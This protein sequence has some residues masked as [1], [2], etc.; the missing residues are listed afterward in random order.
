MNLNM[1]RHKVETEDIILSTTKNCETL[2]KQ[3]HTKAEET[4]EFR[5]TRPKKIS[6]QSTYIC[7]KILVGW[8]NKLSSLQFFIKH[9]RRK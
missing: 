1:I 7:W 4:L 8:F 3:T 9:N 5:L 6:Y 2:I